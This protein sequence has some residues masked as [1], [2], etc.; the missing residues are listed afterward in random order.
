MTRASLEQ[1]RIEV[2][3]FDQWPWGR[4][5]FVMG[6]IN[7]TPDSFSGDGLL[8]RVDEA[9]RRARAMVE[10][11]ADILDVGGE[12]TRPGHQPVEAEEEL[13]RVIPVIRA[14]REALPTVPISVDTN[15]A[16]VAEAALAAGATMI[17]DV[18][19][20][21][22]DPDMA[23]VAARSGVPVVIMHDLE[24]RRADELI[25]RLIR[26]LAARI[27]RALAAGVHWERIIIDP[28]FGFG[29]EPELNLLLLRRLRDLTVLGRPILVGTSRKRTIGFVLGTPPEDRLEGTAATV[30]LS[31]A[32]GA[33][34]VR[35]HDVRQ[36]VR[37]VRMSDAV[38][39]GTW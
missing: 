29:K 15:K 26:D 25:P 12:S 37:V 19:G 34:I 36:M 10:A 28:G 14:I 8:G 33:D 20:L 16:V 2:P 39:R 23:A 30:A 5:T 3:P 35:V 4:R 18:R 6:I 22:G 13:R 24:I 38:V 21:T 27:E 7:A 32:N 9:V 17:N 31:I 11:G 1:P